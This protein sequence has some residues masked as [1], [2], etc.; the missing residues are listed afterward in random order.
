MYLLARSY[1]AAGDTENAGVWMDK[2]KTNYPNI[3]TTGNS[4]E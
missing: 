1:E 4:E 3:D 2:V